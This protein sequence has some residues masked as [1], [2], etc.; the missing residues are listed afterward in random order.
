MASTCRGSCDAFILR[1]S[2]PTKNCHLNRLVQYAEKTVC[3][4]VTIAQIEKP[5]SAYSYRYAC[6][7][8]NEE[9]PMVSIPKVVGVMS[10]GFLLCL[11]LST[12]GQAD[13]AASEQ[14]AN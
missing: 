9:A 5:R 10:C 11:G 3:C 4:L 12:A 6:C 1:P 8:S 7:T 13:N 2:V 14:T